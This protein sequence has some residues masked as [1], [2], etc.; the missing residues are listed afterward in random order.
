MSDEMLIA[1]TQLP[2]Y[3]RAANF[4]DADI[5]TDVVYDIDMLM[6]RITPEK[7]LETRALLVEF[8][9]DLL[10]QD[11]VDGL[12]EADAMVTD[13]SYLISDDNVT[14][15]IR[16]AIASVMVHQNDEVTWVFIRRGGGFHIVSGGMSYGDAPTDACHQIWFLNAL[17]L[18]DELFERPKAMA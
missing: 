7:I 1:I 18:F 14:V 10:T 4:D 6:G 8:H 5:D 12:G 17:N 15:I 9:S 2:A 11:Q 16:N 3:K 13:F